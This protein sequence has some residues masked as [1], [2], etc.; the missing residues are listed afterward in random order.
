MDGSERE[1]Q[2]IYLK[3]HRKL[4]RMELVHFQEGA[5]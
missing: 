3:E 4:A 2:G 1:A 5:N